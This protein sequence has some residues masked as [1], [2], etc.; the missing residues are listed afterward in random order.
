MK[1]VAL[2]RGTSLDLALINHISSKTYLKIDQAFIVI[3]YE[4]QKWSTMKLLKL[5]QRRA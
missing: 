1:V 4:H 2:L 5:S 3:D